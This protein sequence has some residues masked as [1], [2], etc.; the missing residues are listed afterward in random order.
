[1]AERKF[2]DLELERHL[3]GE[4]RR[5]FE[6]EASEADR[7][8][9]A[10]LRAEHEAFLRETDVAAEVAAI[11]RRAARLAPEPRT[12]WF[13]WLVP[14]GALAAAAVVLLV[15]WRRTPPDDD[16]QWKGDGI[17]LV[18]HMQSGASSQRL[19]TNDTVA[20]GTHIRFQVTAPRRGY[21]A[22]IGVDPKTATVYVPASAYDPSGAGLLPG[23]IVLDDTPGDE[24]FYAVFASEPFTADAAM[25]ALRDH[26]A[27][28]SGV[29]HSTEVVLHKA[30]R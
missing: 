8:R 25:A 26:R 7:A 27:L 20:A 18:I 30:S 17:G 28:P 12:P 23:A 13:R 9:L 4:L 14:V 1:M 11:H 6:R 24:R 16:L 15:F 10:E 3:A 2:V 19:A 21:V 5:D 22:V 29:V